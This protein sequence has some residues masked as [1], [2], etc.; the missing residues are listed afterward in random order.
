MIVGQRIL[1]LKSV[2]TLTILASI[3]LHRPRRKAALLMTEGR[4]LFN[5]TG[6]CTNRAFMQPA[7]LLLLPLQW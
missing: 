3:V 1:K 6:V 2:K 7:D 5:P 4:G